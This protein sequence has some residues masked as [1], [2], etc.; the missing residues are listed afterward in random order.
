M[1]QPDSSSGPSSTA[2]PCSIKKSE[3]SFLIIVIGCSPPRWRR[4][5][6]RVMST[7]SSRSTLASRA[8]SNLSVAIARA[9]AISVFASPINFPAEAFSSG[10]SDPRARL[11][12]EIGA[13]SPVCARRATLRASRSAAADS[14]CLAYPRCNICRIHGANSNLRPLKKG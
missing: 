9:L 11:A 8:L 12:S 4:R 14:P 7:T 10:K 5:T 6:G 13:L 2:Y 1:S 3:I